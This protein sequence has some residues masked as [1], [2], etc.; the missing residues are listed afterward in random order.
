[1]DA[2][3]HRGSRGA[4]ARSRRDMDID[5]L[6]AGI[7][8]GPAT[9]YPSASA[10]LGSRGSSSGVSPYAVASPR[11]HAPAATP[12]Y[13][14]HRVQ[15]RTP[16]YAPPK[17]SRTAAEA[18]GSGPR[19][20][21]DRR[22]NETHRSSPPRRS[23]G[24]Q[25]QALRASRRGPNAPRPSSSRAATVPTGELKQRLRAALEELAQIKASNQLDE[26]RQ[27][28]QDPVP[29]PSSSGNRPAS[30]QSA[31]TG[32]PGGGEEVRALARRLQVSE[33]LVKKLHRRTLA[34]EAALSRLRAGGAVEED[35]VPPSSPLGPA[36]PSPGGPEEPLWD[37]PPPG[38]E[39]VSHLESLNQQ[40]RSQVE[41]LQKALARA[42]QSPSADGGAVQRAYRRMSAV[43]QQYHAMLGRRAAALRRNRA[44]DEEAAQLIG[45]LQD[46]LDAEVAEKEME[47]RV[48]NAKLFELEQRSCDWFVDKRLLESQLARLSKE[49]AERDRIDAQISDSVSALLERI[50]RLEGENRTLRSAAAAAASAA[51]GEHRR[52][53]GE[54]FD[55]DE[56]EEEEGYGEEE[57]VPP[58]PARRGSAYSLHDRDRERA[59]GV[60]PSNPAGA[61]AWGRSLP[62]DRGESYAHARA[63]AYGGP[64]AGVGSATEVLLP[65][66]RFA[67]PFSS[68]GSAKR[69]SSR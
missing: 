28:A 5:E 45:L 18:V 40:L 41:Y 3:G 4:K 48:F 67:G 47:Q 68:S 51:S 30:T 56:E 29:P 24:S 65:P 34:L 54:G 10:L 62:P 13:N 39:A 31:G 25:A 19:S 64:G 60:P 32:G 43:R 17:Q 7:D 66:S 37:P 8:L 58:A 33:A 20:G 52:E 35:G 57:Q 26:I 49:L 61:D 21:Q 38:A 50:E 22:R 42:A 59:R 63:H 14:E 16:T 44:L 55:D 15:S 69:L 2:H 1:M 11:R 46:R 53:D 6:I 27:M 9:H 12:P 23:A 36:P